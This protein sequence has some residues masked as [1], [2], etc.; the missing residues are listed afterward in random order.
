MMMIS[1]DLSVLGRHLRPDRGDVRRPGG[2]AGAGRPG[3]H[4]PAA[5]V[6]RAR[7]SASFPRIGDPAA[8]YAP[9][10]PA[11]R[12]ARPARAA[13]GLLVRARA[14]RWRSTQCRRGRAAARAARRPAATPPASGSV[15]ADDRRVEPRHGALSLEAARRRGRVHQPRSGD[16]RATALDGADLDR[17][18]PARSWRW[19]GSRARARPPWPAPCIGLEP[20]TAR[21]GARR[22]RA[23][24]ATARGRCKA[25][26]RRVQMILQDPAGA[27]NPRHTRLRVGRRGAAAAQAG[28]APTRT[29]RTEE[30]LVADAL[31][32][33]G[34]R[35]PERLFLRYPHELSG[36]QRQR[37]LI[38]GALALQPRP[39]D[40][41]RAGLQPRRLDPRRDPGAAAQAAR[42][43]RAGRARGDPR[44]RP[45]L[46]HRRP[47]RRDVPRPDRRGRPD[48]GGAG[49]A[50]APL[51]AGAAVGGARRSSG[52][53]RSC[54]TGEIPDPT[55]IPHGLP[56]P[57]AL[58]GAGRR[59]GRG[60]RG[61][62]RLPVARR[63]DGAA[64][65]A[66]GTGAAC[67]LVAARGGGRHE[68]GHERGPGRARRPRCPREMY[69][70][71]DALAARARR[72]CCS[73]SGS[74]SAGSTTSG[75][76]E[77]RPGR[78][79]RRA[80][81]SRCV[82]TSDDGGAPARGVQRLPAPRLA[83][84]PAR[85]RARRPCCDAAGALRC[86]YHSWTYALDGRLL[87]A[88]HTELTEDERAGVLAAPGRRRGAGRASSSSTST[89]DAAG[90]C[91]ESVGRG[92]VGRLAQL[93][94]G[95]A[96][97]RAGAAPTTWPP[98][99][100]CSPRT[101]TSATTAARCTPS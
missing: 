76:T 97:D 39:A 32:S 8:R 28:P 42:R 101:T 20:P 68:P 43:A 31:S 37:V 83:A 9:S 72:G 22:R 94:D 55:R 29:G 73:A 63:C 24:D 80:W 90:R 75:S 18:A 93:R 34:L 50:A 49:R 91:A 60:G 14:A 89:P 41:R 96:G 74:A 13:A 10:G 6:R 15:S 85:A 54:S 100:R 27:L 65:R 84:V 36:G 19:W 99:T 64:R 26:R 1:H 46:E 12:P 92:P 51:H 4:R 78:G 3:V 16:G 82:V 77:P 79:R 33:A 86:P 7:S 21:R 25:F 47:D 30:Q 59:P 58:P 48:R 71:P 87:R 44:P 57:P 23:A 69:V 35:P 11:G 53:S 2:R 95:R 40:R 17:R 67:H 5:P 62:R 98:T 38:A 52:S 66:R 70:D 81:A 45:G 56:V 61:R 88:P